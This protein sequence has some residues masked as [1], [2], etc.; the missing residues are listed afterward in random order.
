[1]LTRS[2]IHK[3]FM[4]FFIELLKISE[5]LVLIQ[6]KPITGGFVEF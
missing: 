2:W 4:I 3:G 1:M 5:L 6:Q